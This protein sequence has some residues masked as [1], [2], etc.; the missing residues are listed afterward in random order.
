MRDFARKSHWGHGSVPVRAWA[1][2]TI[3]LVRRRRCLEMYEQ[4]RREHELTRDQFRA[5]MEAKHERWRA[6][7]DAKYGKIVEE[8]EETRQEQRRGM[9]AVTAAINNDRQVTREM[10]Q[11]LRDHREFLIDI[12]HG[13]RANT[14]GLL[15]V[16]DELRREDGPS[17]AGA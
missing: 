4:F 17:A 7:L 3:G 14:E 1:H 9:G 6:E 10:L 8:F 11:E 12:R 5:E 16:L 2:G 13:I 15:R